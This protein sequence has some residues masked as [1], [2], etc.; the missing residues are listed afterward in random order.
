MLSV[1]CLA[2]MMLMLYGVNSSLV[3]L[4]V[5]Q[6]RSVLEH[7]LVLYPIPDLTDLGELLL[8]RLTEKKE[9]FVELSLIMS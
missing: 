3:D 2:P 9:E 6:E 7:V 1:C 4:K 8:P 5:R